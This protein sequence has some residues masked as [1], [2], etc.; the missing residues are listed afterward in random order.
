MQA[1]TIAE[2][3]FC[4]MTTE[5]PT[6]IRARCSVLKTL[7][8]AMRAHPH[9]AARRTPNTECSRQQ[10]H[11]CRGGTLCGFEAPARPRVTARQAMLYE[12]NRERR[13]TR[14]FGRN[15]GL[16]DGDDHRVGPD[17]VLDIAVVEADVGH[18]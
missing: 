9:F 15:R 17:E 14:T 7:P 6:V 5:G 4:I 8:L 11:S 2:M 12:V 3:P 18:P 1:L 13:I 10:A 16:L